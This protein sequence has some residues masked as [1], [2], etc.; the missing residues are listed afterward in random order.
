VAAKVITP[1][2]ELTGLPLPI[3]PLEPRESGVLSIPGAPDEH[4]HFHPEKSPTLLT[5]GGLAVRNSR[6][7]KVG[8][9]LHHY[10]YHNTFVGP[11]LPSNEDEQFKISVLAAAG[12]V[13]RRAIK[14]YEEN[15]WEIVNLDNR[16]HQQISKRI[17]VD[18]RKPLSKFYAEYI[19]DQQ[20][21][22]QIDKKIIDKFL[23]YHSS[24]ELKR[25]LASDILSEVLGNKILSLDLAESHRELKN[26]GLIATKKAKTFFSVAKSIVRHR[27][28]QYFEELL[29]DR[30]AASW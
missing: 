19:S 12:V 29:E 16:E 22:D 27:H 5:A 18:W 6:V 9:A 3:K 4:H 15:E 10:G 1:S 20:L 11:E 14:I 13:P 2:C 23:N 21:E 30:F 26:E 7:Q 25:R 17:S 8:Y 24:P 28:M